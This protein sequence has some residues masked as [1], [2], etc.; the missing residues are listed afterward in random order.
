MEIAERRIHIA[1]SKLK[2]WKT[3]SRKLSKRKMKNNFLK[4]QEKYMQDVGCEVMH[5]EENR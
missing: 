4:L 2:K 3:D 5:S 1:E